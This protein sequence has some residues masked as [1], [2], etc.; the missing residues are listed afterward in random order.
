MIPVP[1]LIAGVLI[2]IFSNSWLSSLFICAAWGLI[3]CIYIFITQRQRQYD[4]EYKYVQN[5]G[6]AA[7][8]YAKITFLFYTIEYFTGF[9]TSFLFAA[10]SRLVK[11]LF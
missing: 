4:F 1:N 3:F 2:G 7:H 11:M 6:Q 8:N 9:C 10:I 5:H